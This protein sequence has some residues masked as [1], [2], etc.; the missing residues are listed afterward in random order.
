MNDWHW[1]WG[2]Y[3]GSRKIRIMRWGDKLVVRPWSEQPL[4]GFAPR[5]QRPERCKCVQWC[6]R[7][8]GSDDVR[9]YGVIHHR[10]CKAS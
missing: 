2:A 4:Q 6:R 5:V 7:L 3:L 8:D 10:M 9:R 1:S